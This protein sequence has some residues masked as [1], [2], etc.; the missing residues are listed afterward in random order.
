[1]SNRCID[2]NNKV[3]IMDYIK[4]CEES[5]F[6]IEYQNKRM[7][8]WYPYAYYNVDK[9]DTYIMTPKLAM[10]LHAIEFVEKNKN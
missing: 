2:I 5:L 10:L 9:F 3:I 7:K 1:M 6:T 4:S 8:M